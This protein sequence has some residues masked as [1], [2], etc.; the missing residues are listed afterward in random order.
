MIANNKYIIIVT[1]STNEFSYNKTNNITKKF[2]TRKII[3]QKTQ[4]TKS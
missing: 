1:R 4:L 2:Q 3:K